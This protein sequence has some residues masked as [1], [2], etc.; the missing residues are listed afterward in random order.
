[1][2]TTSGALVILQSRLSIEAHANAASA[3]LS[4][5]LSLGLTARAITAFCSLPARV[6]ALRVD[7]RGITV[8]DVDAMLMLESLIV[9]WCHERSGVSRI[10]RPRIRAR[11]A[12]VA[13][14]CTIRDAPDAELRPER[15]DRV[16][17]SPPHPFW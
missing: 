7:L 8:C 13:Y 5:P 2:A 14:P 10:T 12:F 9:E 16:V 15:D 17:S 4:G 11:D 6:R 1:M 3:Y